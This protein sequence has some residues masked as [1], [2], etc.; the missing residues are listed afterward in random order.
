MELG[1][2]GAGELWLEPERDPGKHLY[3]FSCLFVL[4]VLLCYVLVDFGSVGGTVF[5]PHLLPSLFV[6]TSSHLV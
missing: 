1:V 6:V 3:F 4:F 5:L 2:V